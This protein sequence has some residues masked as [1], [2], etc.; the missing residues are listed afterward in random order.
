MRA[1]FWENGNDKDNKYQDGIVS[2]ETPAIMYNSE[3]RI[4][5]VKQ[6]KCNGNAIIP[7]IQHKTDNYKI[8]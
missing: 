4:L 7:R 5:R 3:T 8:I 1:T 6:Y 2:E